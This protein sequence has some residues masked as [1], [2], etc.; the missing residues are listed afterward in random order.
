MPSV[1][2][3]VIQTTTGTGTGNLTLA[4]LAAGSPPYYYRNFADVFGTGAGNTFYYCIR[5]QAA[6]QFEVGVGYML[7]ATVMVRAAVLESS[8]AN[9]LVN[10]GAG[11]KEV[12]C[13]MPAVYQNTD[14][15]DIATYSMARGA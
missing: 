6:A 11:T 2:N 5:N 7:S 12:I 15:Y 1:G 4:S 13:D 8:N 9:A 3:L 14:Q 10:F